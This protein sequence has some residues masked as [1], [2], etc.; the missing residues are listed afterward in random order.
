MQN[1]PFFSIVMPV[2]NVA[3]YL[4]Q[5]IESILS[6]TFS[7]FEL[8]LVND[9]SPDN[10]A[11]ICNRYAESD[12]RIQVIC[13]SEN[14]GASHARS[15][16][17]Q[18]VQGK[19]VLFADSDD[20]LSAELLQIAYTAVQKTYADVIMFNAVEIY[21][22]AENSVYDKIDVCF[23]AQNYTTAEQVRTAVIEIEKTTLFGYLWNKFYS[24]QLLQRANIDFCDMPLNED[25]KFNIDLFPF[26]SS[27]VT[28]DYIGY[29]Y[30][31]RDNQSLT[32]K[33]VKNYFDLQIMR[34]QL[35]LDFYQNFNMCTESVKEALCGIY[36]R[37]LFS[38][39]QRNFDSRSNLYRKDRVAF[40]KTQFDSV[41]FQEL[42]PYSNP[43]GMLLKV[44]HTFLKK[45]WIWGSLMIAKIIYFVKE[46][47]PSVFSRLKQNR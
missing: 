21:V 1:T 7:D 19:Y 46:K 24:V 40:L 34:I 42:M 13:L 39:L 5:T 35:L 4:P 16:G 33:F 47:F 30:Y 12:G 26:V 36:E 14:G 20:T 41:L 3:S 29:Q 15:V 28:L 37:S 43:N 45:K 32:G 6:Q 31:K 22:N 9:C 25:F 2:Y 18:K 8:I 11:E 17:L 44:M 38:A 23:P 27:L 10:S